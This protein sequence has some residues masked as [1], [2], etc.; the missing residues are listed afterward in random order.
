MIFMDGRNLRI[1]SK[2]ETLTQYCFDV[3]PPSSTSAQHQNNIGSMSCV[4]WVGPTH[5]VKE[6][7]ANKKY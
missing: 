2:R 1:P 3:G 6:T 4:C 5:A 7:P